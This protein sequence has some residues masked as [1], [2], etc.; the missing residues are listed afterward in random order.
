MFKVEEP[1]IKE[2]KT[3]TKSQYMLNDRVKVSDISRRL[4]NNSKIY[5]NSYPKRVLRPKY[6]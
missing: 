4:S 1:I 6:K 2:T 5:K 3:K